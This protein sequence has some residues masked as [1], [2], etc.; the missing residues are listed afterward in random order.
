MENKSHTCLFYAAT[1]LLLVVLS[2][3]IFQFKDPYWIGMLLSIV[4]LVFVRPLPVRQWTFIDWS[5]SILVIYD[6]IS[7]FY[8]GCAL[9]A[10]GSMLFSSYGFAVYLIIRKLMSTGKFL[11]VVQVGSYL[12]IGAA[13]ALTVCSFFIF[14]NSVLEA[15]F[16]DTYHFR[17]LFHPLGYVTNVW[18]EVLLIL[19][20]WI[21]LIRR[22]SGIFIFLTIVAILLSFSRGVYVALGIYL[23]IWIAATKSAKHWKPLVA[24]FTAI[25]LIAI[26]F[27]S[28]MKTTLRMNATVSQQRSSEWRVN[29]T[30]DAWE[31]FKKYPLIGYGN[32][33]YTLAIDHSQNQDS[34]HPFATFAPNIII[35]LL[36]EKGVVGIIPYLLLLI[37]II[38]TAISR[39]KDEDTWTIIATF[40]ALMVKEMTQSTM[41]DTPIV[42]LMFFIFLAYLQKPTSEQKFIEQENER[43]PYLIP[44]LLVV[45]YGSGVLFISLASQGYNIPGNR[46][47]YLV[48][49]GMECGKDYLKTKQNSYAEKA[50]SN[51]KEAQ[52][53]NPRDVQITYLLSQIYLQSGKTEQGYPL[54]ENLAS[55]YPN[56]S[57]YSWALGNVCYQKGLSEKSI[58]PLAK[59]IFY[60][61]RLLTLKQVEEWEKNDS[62]FYNI[63]KQEIYKYS[64]EHLQ[65]PSD[66][67][68]YG[69]ILHWFGDYA[70]AE[71]AL[72]KAV[73]ALPNLTTSWRLLGEEKKYR[74]LEFGAFK[75]DAFSADMPK[76]PEM[77]D[78]LL[79]DIAYKAKF[80]M[81]YGAEFKH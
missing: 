66:W 37:G 57:L 61:P 63:L 27:P 9:P 12:P 8:A 72:R 47:P 73:Q 36:I 65:S 42:W 70:P 19:L 50:I 25:A 6:L 28:E 1:I 41:I 30:F 26:L 38:K 59:A 62:A 51:L 58:A 39:R 16:T 34:T 2:I 53:H 20:G 45:V 15:G 43:K 23:V 14:R 35:K 64:T 75:K 10:V 3:E 13:L 29:S 18:A 71:K 49:Q 40:S 74:L 21:C 32:G 67:A 11:N 17:F 46:I 56:N 48:N 22:Y 33:N 7:C 52:Q 80:Y 55:N 69:F 5:L 68:R 44:G 76:E 79:L 24:V 4:A 78:H 60:S 77:T 31:V 54:L 81:W